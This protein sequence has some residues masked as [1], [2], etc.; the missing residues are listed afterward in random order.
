MKIKQY[1]EVR[2]HCEVGPITLPTMITI[3][4]NVYP[5]TYALSD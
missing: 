2:A 4:I 5:Y 1:N 3:S